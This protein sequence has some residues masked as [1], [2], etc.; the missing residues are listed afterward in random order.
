MSYYF[1]PIVDFVPRKEMSGAKR[2]RLLNRLL[3]KSSICHWCGVPVF[4]NPP[5]ESNQRNNT[6][7]VDHIISRA[8]DGA[9]IYDN[10]VLACRRCNERRS[11]DTF[12]AVTHKRQ[13]ASAPNRLF[14]V[15]ITNGEAV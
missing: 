2:T 15:K 13:K 14:G 8:E 4:K 9:D 5:G 6:A 12:F 11:G 7:T 10:V 3:E 1:P